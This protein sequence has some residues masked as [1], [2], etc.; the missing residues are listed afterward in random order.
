M[1]N[2]DDITPEVVTAF[3]KDFA[4]GSLMPILRTQI[5]PVSPAPSDVPVIALNTNTFKTLST[6]HPNKDVFIFFAGPACFNCKAVWPSFEKLVRVLHEGSKSLVFAYVDLTYNELQEYAG[7]FSF[8]T[9]RLYP[10]N[11]ANPV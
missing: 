6:D 7:V 1:T 3:V 11:P 9:L 10:W 5:N 4:D 8:P 2:T